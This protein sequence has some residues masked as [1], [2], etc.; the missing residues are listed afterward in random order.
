MGRQPDNSLT[1]GN[2]WR[3]LWNFT[4]PM[5]LSGLLQQLYSIAD[6]LI[7]GNFSGDVALATVG[8]TAS[9]TNF[10]ILFMMALR[11]GYTIQ[12]SYAFGTRDEA[13]I[14]RLVT[15]VLVSLTAGLVIT[16]LPAYLFRNQ[17]FALMDTPPQ[18]IAGAGVYLS[19]TFL[20]LPGLL[21]YNLYSAMLRAAGNSK[22]PLVAIVISSVINVALDLLF[23]AV[24]PWGVAGAAWATIIAQAFSALYLIL[25]CYKKEPLLHI[26]LKQSLFDWGLLKECITLSLPRIIQSFMGSVGSMALQ[27]VKNGFGMDVITGITTAYKVDTLLILPAQNI[28][29]AVSVFTGQNMGAGNRKRAREGLKKGTIMAGGVALVIAVLLVFWGD[30]FLSLFGIS[31][32]SVAVGWKFFKLFGPF[33]IFMG[34]SQAYMG[35][36]QGIKQVKFVAFTLVASLYARIAVSFAFKGVLGSDVIAVS[37]IVSVMLAFVLYLWKYWRCEKEHP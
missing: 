9:I 7:L 27:T 6:S 5:I 25:Y 20:G 11:T 23:V 24:F 16:A 22:T 26:E 29:A 3:V 34:I 18:L 17:I 10:A 35:Y 28:S 33:Y 1:E 30:F 37:E 2:I 14:K 31:P 36:L 21:L 13:K 8:V 32:A 19:I 15:T 12:M 4:L